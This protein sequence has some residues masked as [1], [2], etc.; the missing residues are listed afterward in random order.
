M[1]IKDRDFDTFVGEEELGEAVR[2][3]AQGIDRDYAGRCPLVCPVLTGSFI[4]AADLVRS[5][6][7]DH[8][9][10]FVKYSS[11]VGTSSSGT[12]SCET[13]FPAGARG[14]DVIIVEDIVETGLSM[15]RM[16]A[17]LRR[18]EPRSVKVCTL[19]LKPA[20]LAAS[21]CAK[22]LHIDYVGMEIADE[23]IV[24]YGMDYDGHGRGLKE[25]MKIS[26]Q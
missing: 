6:T 7:V 16:L 5:L 2:R 25:V 8:E 26:R 9:V 1:R 11:Y 22:R 24:G 15:E 4:F 19:F 10:A 12:V 18:L 13:A 21:P 3:V 17:D 20:V 14:R 23:F